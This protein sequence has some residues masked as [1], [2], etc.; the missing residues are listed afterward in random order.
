MHQ[1]TSIDELDFVSVDG[2]RIFVPITEQ[3]LENGATVYL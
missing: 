1:G 3:K 2:G